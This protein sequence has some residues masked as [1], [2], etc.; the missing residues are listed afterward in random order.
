[1]TI[2]AR[3]GA[4]GLTLGPPGLRN[5]AT[6]SSASG[7]GARHGLL[8]R[9]DHVARVVVGHGGEERQ[10]DDPRA[11][12][13]GDREDAGL[14]A[15]ALAVVGVEVDR[16]EVQAGADPLGFQ[17]VHEVRPVG[18]EDREQ[19]PGVDLL[20][21]GQAGQ[22]EP[23]DA[24][25]LA[26]VDRGDLGPPGVEARELAELVDAQGRLDVG[27]VVLE[28]GED[29]V[30]GSRCL[31]G[32]R[33]GLPGVAPHPV[34]APELDPVGELV[35]IR[36]HHA[37]LPRRHVLDRV[38]GEAGGGGAVGGAGADR[39]TFIGGPGGVGGV[40]QDLDVLAAGPAEHRAD[41]VEIRG[42]TGEVDRDDRLGAR[43]ERRAQRGR[44]QVP[45]RGVDVGEDRLR[46]GGDR[47]VRGGGPGEGR[48]DD[49]VPLGQ[50]HGEEADMEGAGA[51]GEGEGVLRPVGCRELLLEL[52][53]QRAGG[54]PPGLEAADDLG[55]LLFADLRAG[56]REDGVPGQHR[57]GV[58]H[59]C[60]AG[61]KKGVGGLL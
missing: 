56:E 8:D 19:V 27:Q 43:R 22:L 51:G 53:G 1:M 37:T 23:R 42:L 25:Q 59:L 34:E 7:R 50:A 12:L 60:R 2:E 54:D 15:E 30:V 52:G 10:G 11:D 29:D 32:R 48:D 47:H 13:L 45:G 41:T 21:V 46:P 58:D 55:D 49:L 17:A 28:A 31:L 57:A 40:L 39:A 33:V 14:V 16:L 38:E 3:G 20:V 9:G 18:G 4:P 26:V 61:C 6:R 35:V 36:R 24:G 5:S 44:V